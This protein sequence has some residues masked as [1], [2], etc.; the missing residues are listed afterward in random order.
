M[1][2][3]LNDLRRSLDNI[4]NALILLLA[5]RFHVTQ[6]VGEYK[7]ANHLP[8]VDPA[9][10][11]TQFARIRALADSAGLDPEFAASFLRLVIDQVV[12][13]HKSF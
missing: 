2:H 9:R 12:Q 5:E 7:K 8:P 4:D 6:K 3:D 1:N 11:K 10:E 13:N